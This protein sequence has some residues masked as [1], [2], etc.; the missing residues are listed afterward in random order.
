MAKIIDRR[1]QAMGGGSKRKLSQIKNL[2]VHYSATKEGSTAA[3]ERYWKG[4]HGWNTGGYHEVILTNG[5]VELNY[6]ADVISNGVGGQNTRMYNICYV[7]DGKPNDKQL[8][9]L[10]ERVNYNRNRFNISVSN[11]KGHR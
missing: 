4:T 9:S 2:A 3:F 6:N 11:V 10:K 7:G 1:K 5:D 8:Q